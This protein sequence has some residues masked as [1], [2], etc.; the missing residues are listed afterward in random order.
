MRGR[1]LAAAIFIVCAGGAL[2]YLRDPAWLITQTTGLRGWERSADGTRFRWSGGLASFFVPSEEQII[3]I[4]N[5]A[6]GGPVNTPVFGC[7]LHDPGE[8]EL[9]EEPSWKKR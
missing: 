8:K 5:G 4:V 1:L 9:S 6:S 2:W 3:R 7:S